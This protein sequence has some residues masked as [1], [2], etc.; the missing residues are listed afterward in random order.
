MG[1]AWRQ[2]SAVLWEG[3]LKAP[4]AE[5]GAARML[6]TLP[7]PPP[8]F[9]AGAVSGT[10]EA[11]T[12]VAAEASSAERVVRHLPSAEPN[13]RA[14]LADQAHEHL[15]R[16]LMLGE[17]DPVCRP[18]TAFLRVEIESVETLDLAG[19]VAAQTAA[20]AGAAVRARKMANLVS[21][22]LAGAT[23]RPAD[24]TAT[25]AARCD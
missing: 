1:D 12:R 23:S 24:R 10:V 2:L 22:W 14:S 17:V 7:T 3:L 21:A 18:I 6:D 19:V 9:D 15:Q 4:G 16:L 5:G 13:R 8:G 25:S 11:L 20:Y